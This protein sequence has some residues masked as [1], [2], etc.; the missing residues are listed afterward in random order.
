MRRPRPEPATDLSAS[1]Q[2]AAT[3]GDGRTAARAAVSHTYAAPGLRSHTQTLR[4]VIVR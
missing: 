1:G 4:F 3:F 2:P